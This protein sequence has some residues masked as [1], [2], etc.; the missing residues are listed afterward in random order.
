MVDSGKDLLTLTL[1]TLAVR[2]AWL[3]RAGRFTSDSS[4]YLTAA[5]NLAFHHVFSHSQSATA[6]IV[7]TVNHPPLYPALIAML[8]WREAAPIAAVIVLQVVL[9]V[10]TVAL[11]YLIARERFNR[12]VALLACAGMIVAPMTSFYTGLVLTETLFTFLV[13]L[14]VF[15]WGRERALLCGIVFG[16]AAL[17]R[18]T[19]LPFLVVLLLLPLLPAWRKDWR[20]YL[21]IALVSMAVSSVWIVRNA[22]VVG[23][24]VPVATGSGLNLLF[25]TIETSVTG[26]QYWTGN[27]W[28]TRQKEIPTFQADEGLPEVER[29]RAR[30]RRAL[31]VIIADPLRWLVVRAKQYPRLF[32]DTGPYILDSG[33]DTN[34]QA[35][36]RILSF[37][38]KMIFVAGNLAVAALAVFGIFI[39]RARF[40]SLSHIMLFPLYLSLIHLPLWIEPRYSLPMMPL[41]AI[42]AAVGAVR[43]AGEQA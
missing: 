33:G 30:V 11:V 32:V 42:L 17:T 7:P 13:T 2:V 29:D 38:I 36:P 20:A 16:L 39:E 25:G 40:V 37:L 35:L 41:V 5:K 12:K 24:F 8:W 27:E 15:L 10:A 28:T 26:G 31:A 22:F 14:G 34:S 1:V 4:L 18:T 3:Q 43:L 9:S 23:R 6:G 19:M 21:C